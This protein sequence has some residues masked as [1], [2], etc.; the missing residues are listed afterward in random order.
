AKEDASGNYKRAAEIYKEAALLAKPQLRWS[1][2]C[3]EYQTQVGRHRLT[4][5]P[6]AR[7]R[8]EEIRSQLASLREFSYVA[9]VLEDKP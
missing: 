1:Y 2:Q 4:G 9:K 7:E 8:A 3:R 5:D 6:G